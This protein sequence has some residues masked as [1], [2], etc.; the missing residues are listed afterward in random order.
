M[1]LPTGEPV[2]VVPRPFPPQPTYQKGKSPESSGRISS[3]AED[4]SPS[5]ERPL[6]QLPNAA[7]EEDLRAAGPSAE[8]SPERQPYEARR[9]SSSMAPPGVVPRRKPVPTR[10]TPYADPWS[11]PG[12]DYTPDPEE[13]ARA[14]RGESQ[15]QWMSLDGME[16]IG[17]GKRPRELTPLTPTFSNDSKPSYER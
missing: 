6:P 15:A 1:Y 9:Y 4:Q 5:D 2:V 16:V 7:G 14:A 17:K 13:Q 3:T 10:G 12:P 11:A 8:R